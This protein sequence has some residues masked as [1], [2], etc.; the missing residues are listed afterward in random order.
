MTK[1]KQFFFFFLVVVSFHII[2]F[3]LVLF[4]AI[5]TSPWYPPSLSFVGGAGTVG[6]TIYYYFIFF[7]ALSIK[8]SF[9]NFPFW[10]HFRS[11]VIL[12]M[13]SWVTLI[14]VVKFVSLSAYMYSTRFM[15][16][17][18]I[19]GWL[20]INVIVTWSLFRGNRTKD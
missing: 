13:K 4:F 9:I 20:V 10:Y 3:L 15:L 18:T 8:W 17:V 14:Y 2:F 7:S 11:C 6:I 5:D 1:T 12:W 19:A 16:A